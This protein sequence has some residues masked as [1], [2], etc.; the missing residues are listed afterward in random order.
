MF[1]M[2]RVVLR[3][4]M[5]KKIIFVAQALWLGGIE[6]ALIN[7]L[8]H[9]DYDR[10][11]VTCLITED[12][13]AMAGQITE[14]CR[15]LV[16]D[17][18]HT[19]SFPKPYRHAR[20]ADLLEEPQNASSLRK[21]AWRGIRLTCRGPEMR[22][23]AA[24]IRKQLS[25]EHFDTCVIYSDRMAEIAVR[26]VSADRF[27]MFYH[28]ADIGKAYHDTYG[29]RRSEKIIAVSQSQC[30]KLKQLRPAFANKMIAIP[31]YVDVDSVLRR[32]QQPVEQPLFPHDGIHLV[33]CGRLAYQKGFDIAIEACATIVN[34][35]F[36]NLHWY[37][38]G[39]GPLKTELERLAKEYGVQEHFHLIGSRNNPFPYMTEA[40]L[41][42]QP[43]R[44]EGYS[45]SILEA[46]V[47][48]CPTVATYGAAGEQ[49]EDG[50]NGTLCDADVG[51][52]T[53][54][55]MRHLQNP[56]LSEQYRQALKQ[57]NFDKTNRDI[58]NKIEALL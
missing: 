18:R 27:L 57:F 55:I 39:V 45:L 1:C 29:Y 31:N 20:L 46:R 6:T 54:A 58:L 47:L 40:D 25:G 51:S 22:L 3:F 11:E 21:L 33:S 30:E 26:A 10:F 32:A 42:V 56:A 50:I 36:E 8:N 13:Q 52:L 23:Y 7:L 19:V 17:R 48:A 35:G 9:L 37:I 24:Y 38:L 49:L 4:D 14:K 12:Y 2:K 34:S 15:L 28:N 53:E 41:Y 5:K 44:S 43:S 16:A